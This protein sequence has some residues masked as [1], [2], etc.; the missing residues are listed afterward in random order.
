MMVDAAE[1]CRAEAGS[2]IF[3]PPD[4]Q[5]VPIDVPEIWRTAETSERE[6]T[7]Q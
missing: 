5:T 6:S 1:I 4:P 3:M 7:D 2:V